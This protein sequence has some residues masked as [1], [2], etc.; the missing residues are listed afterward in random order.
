MACHFPCQHTSLQH[1]QVRAQPV[2]AAEVNTYNS[3]PADIILLATYMLHTAGIAPWP[4]VQPVSTSSIFLSGPFTTTASKTPLQAS[5]EPS[6]TGISSSPT[7]HGIIDRINR[8]LFGGRLI[9]YGPAY[10]ANILG[11]PINFFNT[12]RCWVVNPWAYNS[13]ACKRLYDTTL[14]II[15]QVGVTGGGT[16]W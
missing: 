8:T 5:I 6:L 3:S 16:V 15:S 11:G 10:L 4:L 7:P 2:R 12:S 1:G 14:D 9:Y 13:A